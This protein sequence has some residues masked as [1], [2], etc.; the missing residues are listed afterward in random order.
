MIERSSHILVS[1]SKVSQELQDWYGVHANRITAIPFGIPQGLAPSKR[2]K[3]KKILLW[4]G[5]LH[6]IKQLDVAL[7]AFSLL[8]KKNE[9][10]MYK[11]VLVG[12]PQQTRLPNSVMALGHVSRD[13]L[14]KIYH[15]ASAL[16]VTSR[17]ESFHFP[18]LEALACGTPVVSVQSACIPELAPYVT[19]VT[20]DSEAIAYQLAQIIRRS[21]AI[22][23]DKLKQEFSWKNY[24]AALM[25]LYRTYGDIAAG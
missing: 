15:E 18:T 11:L 21:P 16:L 12:V 10:R 14:Q 6:P 1:S 22:N 20:E 19:R 25:H 23:T 7:S 17:Y 24:S 5:S 2:Y 4:V 13:N 8:R 3:P 9:Y